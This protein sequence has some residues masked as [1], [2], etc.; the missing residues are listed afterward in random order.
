MKKKSLF[1]FLSAFYLDENQKHIKQLAVPHRIKNC[2]SHD[3][4][5]REC[6]KSTL[7]KLIKLEIRHDTIYMHDK[8]LPFY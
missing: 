7:K 4:L 1:K 8:L 5:V 2:S 3:K 6:D